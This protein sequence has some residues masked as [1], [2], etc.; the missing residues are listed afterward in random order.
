MSEDTASLLPGRESINSGGRRT[1]ALGRIANSSQ[2]LRH[3]RRVPLSDSCTAAKARYAITSPACAGNAM[4]RH[5]ESLHS[6]EGAGK[7]CR[8]CGLRRGATFRELNSVCRA[9]GTWN[10]HIA[11]EH[12]TVLPMRNLQLC[13]V[14]HSHLSPNHAVRRKS[15]LA[16]T[17][18][19]SSI[20]DSESIC[21]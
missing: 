6:G 11:V 15:R 5:R 10:S 3:V 21:K 9:P 1:S 17:S 18:A 13:L 20:I 2:T 4:H 8:R 16:V 14:A 7:Q 19:W 12:P